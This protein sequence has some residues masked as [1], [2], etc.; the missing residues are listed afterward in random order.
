MREVKGGT[1]YLGV[2]PWDSAAAALSAQLTGRERRR[3]QTRNGRGAGQTHETRIR[4]TAVRRT[5]V[6]AEA[7]WAE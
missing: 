1:G 4:D 7:R 2:W 5:T 3:H 6:T